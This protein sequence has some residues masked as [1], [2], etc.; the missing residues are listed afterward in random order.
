MILAPHILVGAAVASQFSNPPLGL[1]F[2]FLVH[3]LLDRIPH[4]EYSIEPLKQIRE[5]ELKYCLPV[6]KRIALDI[7]A[8]YTIL[9]LVVYVGYS[10]IPFWAWAF[11]GFFGIL[12][13]G[14]TTMLFMKQG[15]RGL[16]YSF[17][18]IFF[19][20]HHKIHYSKKIGPPPLR[21]GLGTQAIAI[22]LA[23]YFLI[24]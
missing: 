16:L 24:F 9:F 14:L 23:L 6:L 2:A 5:R 11:G 10:E 17:L 19:L 15:R 22:L 4:S 3:F 21:I 1:I 20:F 18:K 12:P 13:D 8:G 7:C